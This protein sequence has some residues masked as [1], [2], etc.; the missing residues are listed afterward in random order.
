M[1]MIL[2][3]I[4]AIQMMMN[5]MMTTM[6]MMVIMSSRNIFIDDNDYELYIAC[7]KTYHINYRAFVTTSR[8][9]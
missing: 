6:R 1:T 9:T 3:M 4:M 5:V 7:N 2:I 8:V